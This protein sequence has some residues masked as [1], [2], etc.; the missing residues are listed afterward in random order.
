MEDPDPIEKGL[1]RGFSGIAR[2]V[3]S[4]LKFR[5]MATKDHY[6]LT[7]R[8]KIEEPFKKH[9]LLFET[10]KRKRREVLENRK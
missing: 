1:K 3:K 6:D 5:Q 8:Y 2:T 7:E 10:E 9:Y 4:D